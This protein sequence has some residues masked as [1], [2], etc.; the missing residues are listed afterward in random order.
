MRS[1]HSLREIKG[2]F[3][4]V[5]CGH[6][7]SEAIKNSQTIIIS[8]EPKQVKPLLENIQ[9]KSILKD[10]VFIS[11]CA[12]VSIADLEN[13]LPESIVIRAMTGV[14]ALIRFIIVFN[15]DKEWL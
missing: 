1:E 6:D 10:K 9:D 3:P 15:E 14:T 13:L 12:G 8:V 2:E 4:D 7:N 5:N 11:V